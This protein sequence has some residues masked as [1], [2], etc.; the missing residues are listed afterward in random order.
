MVGL[1]V[2][3]KLTEKFGK[4]NVG[5]YRD[6]GLALIEGVN[7]RKADKARK[8]LHDIFGQIGLKITAQVNNQIVNFLDITLDLENAKFAPYRK[9]NN[10]P[11]YVDSRSNHPPSILKQIPITIN[12]R[13]S[14]P[15]HLT[16]NPSMNA[17]L[18]MKAH[19]NT[20][21]TMFLWNIQPTALLLHHLRNEGA[22][23]TLSGSTPRSENHQA[24]DVNIK[25]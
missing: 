17:N 24:I 2:L 4:E 23:E 14:L 6:D 7:G 25:D 13:I 3:S 9:P 19:L 5:L 15:F 21:I 1:F 10:Q 22:K 18:S 12:K 16:K 11:L 20:A 8:M